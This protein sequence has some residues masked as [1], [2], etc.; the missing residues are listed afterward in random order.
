MAA[1]QAKTLFRVPIPPYH[2]HPGGA[3]VCTEPSP[4]VY[5]LTFSSPP[6]NRLTRVSCDAFLE[7]LDLVEFGGY[8][9]GVVVT[10]SAIPKF[11]SNGLDLELAMAQKDFFPD[12][13]YKLFRRLLT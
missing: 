5:L 10:T 4:A 7:A 8:P 3:I 2:S 9:P 11:Y 13:L 6:D 12:K 1:P